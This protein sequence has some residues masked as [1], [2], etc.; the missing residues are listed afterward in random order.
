MSF[1]PAF[2]NSSTTT[3]T[4]DSIKKMREKLLAQKKQLADFEQH[5]DEM[6]Q[7]ARLRQEAATEGQ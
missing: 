3:D 5:L 1:H 7:A 2:D 4:L 6:E